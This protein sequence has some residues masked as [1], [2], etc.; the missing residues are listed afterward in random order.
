MH[1]ETIGKYLREAPLDFGSQSYNQ[2]TVDLKAATTRV[3]TQG[4]AEQTEII[5]NL[6]SIADHLYVSVFINLMAWDKVI[7][8]LLIV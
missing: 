4:D 2:W 7:E 6:S 1:N 3:N 5:R 8:D